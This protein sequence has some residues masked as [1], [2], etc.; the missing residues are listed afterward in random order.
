MTSPQKMWRIFKAEVERIETT[1]KQVA[2]N[3]APATPTPP[4]NPDPDPVMPSF[5]LR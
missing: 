1:A 4:M 2:A 3:P 5:I